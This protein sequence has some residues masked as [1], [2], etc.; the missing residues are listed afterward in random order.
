MLHIIASFITPFL[1]Y[2]PMVELGGSGIIATAVVG[3]VIGN[4]YALRFTPEYRLAAITILPTLA[5]TIQCIIFLLVGLNIQSILLR[6]S[7]IPMVVLFTIVGAMIAV[8]IMG[9]FIWVY[10]F[11]IFLPRFLFPSLKKKDPYPSWKYPFIISWA[12]IRGGISLAAALAVPGLTFKINNVDIRDLLVFI[13][14]CVIFVTLILQGLSLPLIIKKLGIDKIG[15]S[16]RYSEHMT[17][18]QARIQMINAALH[19]LQEYQKE[20]KQDER[21]MTEVSM[22]IYE[23]QMLKKQFETRISDHDVQ[24]IHDEQSELKEKLSLLC[25]VMA[26]EKA[27]L[28]KLWR[29]NQIN[30]KTRNKLATI[31]DH[32]IQRHLI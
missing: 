8:V 22:H 2:I 15:E 28:E 27:A 14:F 25:Q 10:G 16:E 13:V 26:V 9:R 20:I 32:Q 3:F 23:Y 30:L 31:L 6:I 11:V 7:S 19:W 18:L 12:G 29:E 21:L 17:E 5:F 4:Q 24:L 1:A